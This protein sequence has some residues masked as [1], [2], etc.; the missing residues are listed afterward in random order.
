MSSKHSFFLSKAPLIFTSDELLSKVVNI[1]PRC[2]LVKS[3][4][5]FSNGVVQKHSG[6]DVK[7]LNRLNDTARQSVEAARK[8]L[9]EGVRLYDI[10]ELEAIGAAAIL[11]AAG[12]K[13]EPILN[14]QPPVEERP[15][16]DDLAVIMY[17]SGS[18]GKNYSYFPLRTLDLFVYASLRILRPFSSLG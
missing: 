16:S 12:A 3:V 18:T 6:F 7:D 5:Y 17:T 15:K 11:A 14:W 4:I 8:A 2:P 10:L 13:S 9:P 1:L